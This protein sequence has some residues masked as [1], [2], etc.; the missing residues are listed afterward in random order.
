MQQET[1]FKFL[2]AKAG[3]ESGARAVPAPY[4]ALNLHIFVRVRKKVKKNVIYLEPGNEY[5]VGVYKK[6]KQRILKRRVPSLYCVT[7][8]QG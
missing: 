7:V 8:A 4:F 2:R 1:L 6:Y 5:N 3:A